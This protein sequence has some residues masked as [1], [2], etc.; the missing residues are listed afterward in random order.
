MTAAPPTPSAPPTGPGLAGLVHRL[1]PPLRIAL[2]LLM[3]ALIVFGVVMLQRG[4][5][6]PSSGGVP[7]GALDAGVPAIGERAPDFALPD[8]DGRIV[9]LSDL[10]GTPVLLNFWATWC[11]PCRAEMPDLQ[12]AHATANGSLVVLTVNIEGRSINA[13]RALVRAFLQELNLTMP[14]VFDSPNADV[15]EQYRLKGLPDSFFIDR[16]GVIREIV[17]GPL[18]QAALKQKLASIR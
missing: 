1:P 5:G 18:T 10:R 2:V 6:A 15:F 12:A 16:E 8:L 9:R 14:V 4:G 13:A 17:I 11:A 7:A 3:I